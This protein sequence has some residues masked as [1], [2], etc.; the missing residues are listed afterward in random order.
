M[1]S[2]NFLR[3]YTAAPKENGWLCPWE[4]PSNRGI[5]QGVYFSQPWY[6]AHHL[7]WWPERTGEAVHRAGVPVWW[8]TFASPSQERCSWLRWKSC[9]R[10][11]A[12]RLRFESWTHQRWRWCVF[13]FRPWMYSWS[14]RKISCKFG[15]A[16]LVFLH[17]SEFCRLHVFSVHRFDNRGRCY[18]SVSK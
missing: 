14:G 9:T 3:C 7:Q 6:I 1:F 11:S 17:D 4:P 5:Y 2:S 13:V 12:Q 10:H 18:Q 8:E 15:I 16:W